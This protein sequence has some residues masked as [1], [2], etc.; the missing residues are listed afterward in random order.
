[1]E[2]HLLI[3]KGS[4]GWGG[5]L[6]VN[7]GQAKK[8]AYITGG[9]RPP[10]VERLCELTG[11]PAV[12][13]FKNGEPPEAEIGLMVIDCGGTLRCG[14]YP[15]RGI[16]TI[17]LHPTGKS[18][19]LAEY[20]HEE[21][22]VSGVTPAGIEVVWPQGEGGTLGIV[23]DDLTGATTLGVLLA[24]SGLKTAAFFDTESFSRNEVEYPAMV[25]SS[26]S[27]PLPKAEA[28]HQVSA[29]VQ[30][31][32]A[33][34]AH[35][36]TKRIDTTLRGG[37]GF[38]IDAML[39]QLPLETVAVVVPA[40]PQSRR[41]LVGGYSVI[42]SVAL[43]RT[44]VARDVR[45][46]VTESWVP[47]LLAAQT[48]HQVGHISLSSVMK[49]EAQIEIDLQ[50]QQQRG[51]RVIVVDAIT[52]EDVD[53]IAGA[54]VA[55]NWNVL[56]VDPG[57]FTER[58]AVRRGLMREARAAA[59]APQTAEQQRGSILVVAGSATPVTKK[60]LQYLIANDPRVCHIPVDAELL[61]DKKNAAEIE[62]QRVVQHAR[63]CIPQQQNAL[64]VFES[65]LT[66]RLLDLQEEEQRFGLSHGQAAENINQGLGSIVR[67]VL[68]C[69]GG[70]IKGLYMTGGDTMVN[71][72]KELG[73]TGIEMIDYVIPQT[74]MVRIIGGDYAGLI[75]VGKGG[76]TGPEDILSTIVERIYKEA[77][78]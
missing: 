58:L 73:A 63:Q 54:V 46:P 52:V 34:G 36:F 43:S 53:A 8:I 6:T 55:L 9:M 66:G 11:W 65:A 30:Q 76:L 47:G 59:L 23:A 72:L 29:A 39:E 48:H 62:V 50:E 15:K 40:M 37:I 17:N 18:G 16:P 4:K 45:T 13:V 41:I 44:D 31:L 3:S 35:Y 75:C 7:I 33:R 57:P 51:V 67:E 14:L 1:M 2:K 32:Q 10:V 27:R 24:R 19:P 69:A 49:G 61:V 21:I 74:D 22:Y 5:P 28:Q 20:I 60:Q 26:D 25:V 68:N 56:A 70:E 78:N 42:D 64:F 12:D 77:Q 71:V 38:E